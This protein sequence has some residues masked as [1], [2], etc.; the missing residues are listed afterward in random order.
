MQVRI[1]VL[2][3]CI[4]KLWAI[5]YN[6]LNEGKMIHALNMICNCLD[7]KNEGH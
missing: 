6:D 4:L 2:H 3:A 5:D 1:L 7:S